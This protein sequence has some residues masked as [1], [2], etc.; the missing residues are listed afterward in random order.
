MIDII[1]DII[2]IKSNVPAL[3]SKKNDGEKDRERGLSVFL[4]EG[5]DPEILSKTNSFLEYH[6]SS[7]FHSCHLIRFR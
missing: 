1:G 6:S 3:F 2:S 4:D 7:P 5:M